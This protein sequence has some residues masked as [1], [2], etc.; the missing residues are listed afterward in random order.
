MV[1]WT[2]Q[3]LDDVGSTQAVAKGLAAMDAPEGT[4]VVA[5][6][7][8]KGQG[9]LGRPW[10]SPVGGLYMSLILRPQNLSRPE[11][12][13]LIAAVAVVRG[14]KQATGLNPLIR[15][16]NDV[17]VN[18]RKMAGVIAEAQTFRH[19]V[20]YMIVGVGVNC[21]TP[22]RQAEGLQGG[23]TSIREEL[24]RAEEV[25]NLKHAILDSLSQLYDDWKEGADVSQAWREALGTVGKELS[26]KLKTEENPFS[27]TAKGVADD[28]S[29]VVEV[30]DKTTAISPEDLEWLRE[31][32]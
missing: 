14:I 31:K 4:T 8:S 7:Q 19:E 1:T 23:A 18:G 28:G 29:L 2:F 16:P 3:E 13:T 15:W 5:K 25:S 30:G 10:I 22:V 20:T 26:L 12:T 11:L 24:G 6:T 9:R 21:N 27:C 17:M 32:D